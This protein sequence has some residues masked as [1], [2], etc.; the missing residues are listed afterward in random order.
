MGFEKVIYVAGK[1]GLYRIVNKTSFGLVAESLLDGRRV[2]VYAH[3]RVSHLADIAIFTTGEDNLPLKEALQR[4]AEKTNG[5]PFDI[6]HLT[7]EDDFRAAFGEIIPEYDR[8][9]VYASDIK[10]FFNWFN[11]LQGKN[12]LPEKTHSTSSEENAGETSQATDTEKSIIKNKKEKTGKQIA[13]AGNKTPSASSKSKGGPKV[14]TPRKA[15]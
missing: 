10:K 4:L 2:P 15:G 11:I 3:Q 5:G 7:T 8:Q 9:K 14:N 13:T 12:L 1:P 6:S